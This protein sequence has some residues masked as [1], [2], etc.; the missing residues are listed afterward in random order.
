MFNITPAP[1]VLETIAWL[2]YTIPVLVLFLLPQR[3]ARAPA[4]P[5]TTAPATSA[6][7]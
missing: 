1:S 5:T 4:S 6:P 3:P 7:N 2:A